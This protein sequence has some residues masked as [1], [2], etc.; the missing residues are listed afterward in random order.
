MVTQA[1]RRIAAII[2]IMS[3]LSVLLCRWP[4][5]VVNSS[6]SLHRI[7]FEDGTDPWA[8]MFQQIIEEI[9]TELRIADGVE[10]NLLFHAMKG[11]P[12]GGPT[13]ITIILVLPDK[14]NESYETHE[15]RNDDQRFVV[16]MTRLRTNKAVQPIGLINI[17]AFVEGKL[18]TNQIALELRSDDQWHEIPSR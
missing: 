12:V 4:R 13:T 10:R 16:K 2:L 15:S 1:Q 7:V 3:V 17:A 5:D 18:L 9:Q 8:D 14:D 11:K 6:E